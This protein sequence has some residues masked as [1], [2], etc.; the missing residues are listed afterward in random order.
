VS[1][2]EH[3]TVQRVQLPNRLAR[4]LRY[5]IHSL[6]RTDIASYTYEQTKSQFKDAKSDLAVYDG[7]GK[8]VLRGRDFG[9]RTFFWSAAVKDVRLTEA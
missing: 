3:E 1:N 6:D 5:Q 4:E 8:L 7:D 2:A 9:D